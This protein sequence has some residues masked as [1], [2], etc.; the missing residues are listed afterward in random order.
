MLGDIEGTE[1][2]ASDFLYSE[3]YYERPM[4]G[5]LFDMAIVGK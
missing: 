4:I 3:T 1:F 2:V 5:I